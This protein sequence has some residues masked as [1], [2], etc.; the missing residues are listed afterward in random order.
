MKCAVVNGSDTAVTI[1][2]EGILLDDD[3]LEIPPVEQVGQPAVFVLPPGSSTALRF[4][5]AI[6]GLEPHGRTLGLWSI[7]SQSAALPP[8]RIEVPGIRRES[9]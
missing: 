2:R 4:S 1:A 3:G 7:H 8:V 5:F 9:S 6:G